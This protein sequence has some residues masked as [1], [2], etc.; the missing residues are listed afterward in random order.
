MQ[1]KYATSWS[2]GV[3]LV[4]EALTQAD[5]LLFSKTC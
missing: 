3:H 5:R 1:P 2:I 4:A